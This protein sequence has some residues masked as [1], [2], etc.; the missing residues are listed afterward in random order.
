MRRDLLVGLLLVACWGR[1]GRAR[2]AR[3]GTVAPV[4]TTGELGGCRGGPGEE[5]VAGFT[6]LGN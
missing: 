4:T 2:V 3:V 5:F 6:R 1:G